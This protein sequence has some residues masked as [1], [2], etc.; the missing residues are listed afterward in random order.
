MDDSTDTD[1][2]R[3]YQE[4][5]LAIL[6]RGSATLEHGPE[7]VL[8]AA[9]G[10]RTELS[11]ALGGYQRFKHQRIFDPAIASGD[12]HRAALAR[13]MKI[14]CIAAGE[15]FRS[16]MSRW[17]PDRIVAEWDR[18]RPAA[19]LTANQLRRHVMTESESITEMLEAY[20]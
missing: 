14:A 1:A 11:A 17:T 9:A 19:R 18:Y 10:L 12:E 16:H 3:R 8:A 15:M 5:A 4:A 13:H 6:A 20:G 7:A 2:L